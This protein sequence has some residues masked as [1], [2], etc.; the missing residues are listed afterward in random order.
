[1]RRHIIGLLL[2]NVVR[3]SVL[4]E[5]LLRPYSQPVDHFNLFE[6]SLTYNQRV[7]V[8][9]RVPAKPKAIFFYTGNESPVEVYVNNTGLMWENAEYFTAVLIFAEHRFYGDSQPLVNVTDRLRYLSATQ[10]M[11]DYAS[12][13]S[14]FRSEYQVDKVVVF[15]GS[16]GGMLSAWMRLKYP[17]LVSGA[18]ASV[19][20]SSAL[21]P[22]PDEYAF[23]RRITSAMAKPCSDTFRRGAEM[24]GK[25]AVS[26]EGRGRLSAIFKTCNPLKTEDEA[27]RLLEWSQAPWSSYAMGNYPY[28][29]SYIISALTPGR[30]GAVLPA[31]P[32]RLACAHLEF[33]TTDSFQSVL[34]AMGEAVSMWYN[35]TGVLSCYFNPSNSSAS[36]DGDDDDGLWGFQYCAEMTF[37]FS[38][39]GDADAFV[40]RKFNLTE[41]SE[42]CAKRWRVRPDPVRAV[43]EFGDYSSF[44][45]GVGNIFFANGDQDPWSDYSLTGCGQSRGCSPGISTWLIKDGAHHADLMFSNPNDPPSFK[46][47]REAQLASIRKW[48]GY[49]LYEDIIF[50]A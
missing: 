45:S 30:E 28:P 32:L 5:C 3:S 48:I 2:V 6:S 24:F 15:G 22:V 34:T 4:A 14:K 7:F 46:L 44:D 38:S 19:F 10:A 17:H 8:C 11:A 33:C 41:T 18:I 37:G 16:Y 21:S 49:P 25:L 23:Y 12:L 50:I 13:I 40:P 35:N 9:G 31:W 26:E 43:E 42:G 36:G 29:S 20:F 47:V 27:M 39:G 1:M